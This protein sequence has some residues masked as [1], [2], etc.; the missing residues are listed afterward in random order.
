MTKSASERAIEEENSSLR[1]AL[2]EE[3]D[4]NHREHCSDEWPHPEGSRCHWPPP[5]VLG[6]SQ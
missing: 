3:W 1:E 4:A 5:E 2:W 6:G